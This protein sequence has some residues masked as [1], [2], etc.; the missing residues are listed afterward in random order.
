MKTLRAL[1]FMLSYPD[2]DT[3]P[4]LAECMDLLRKEGWV[5]EEDIAALEAFVE[6]QAGKDSLDAQEDYVDLFDRTPS[7]SL[8]LF[9]HVHGDSRDRGQALVDLLSL[10]EEAGLEAVGEETPDYLPMFLEYLSL[11]DI[12]KA[13]E[14]L[15]GI[16]EIPGALAERHRRRESGY[17]PVF[18]ALTNLAAR[19]PDPAQISAALEKAGGEAFDLQ[20][21][22]KEW[23]EQFAFS[24][25]SLANSTADS[26]CP[27]ARD[28]LERMQ[29]NVPGKEV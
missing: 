24:K 8:H 21:L 18:A 2:E 23:E 1:S 6:R 13:Q 3:P 7:L 14:G 25:D 15:A 5:S 16:V 19:R 4:R 20:Q 17:A 29:Q 9:E 28:M 22:D 27:R 10:Y 11:L 26:G 12:E